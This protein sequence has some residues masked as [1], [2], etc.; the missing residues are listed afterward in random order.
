[1]GRKYT[2]DLYTAL[3]HMVKDTWGT[4]WRCGKQFSVGITQ[5]LVAADRGDAS[6]KAEREKHFPIQLIHRGITFH[7]ED[8]QASVQAD[9]E[10]IIAEIS[11]DATL[12]NDTIHGVVAAAAL[13]RVL[14][15]GSSRLHEFLEAVQVICYA[16]VLIHCNCC[17]FSCAVPL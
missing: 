9:K 13:E 14:K 10:K 16:S 17:A 11:A 3:E 15:E 12:L 6:C 1:M 5:G 8:G 4:S 2:Y 7:C